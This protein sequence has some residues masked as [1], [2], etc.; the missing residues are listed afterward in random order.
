M[1]KKQIAR[2]YD[3]QPGATIRSTE[4]DD[5][6][7]QLVASVNE[8][9]DCGDYSGGLFY[10][11]ASRVV[12]WTWSPSD[13][14]SFLE[15]AHNTN[16]TVKADQVID[17]TLGQSVSFLLNN[18]HNADGTVKAT[19]VVDPD[20]ALSDLKAFLA[21]A[22][23]NDGTIKSDGISDPAL[24]NHN[25][26]PYSHREIREELLFT[27]NEPYYQELTYDANGNLTRIDVYTDSTK[28]TQIGYAIFTY[29]ANGNLIQV[30]YSFGGITRTQ[31]LNYDASGNLVSIDQT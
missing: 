9:Y 14:K 23:Y 20:W 4:V 17:A 7:N 15:V 27:F 6:L 1:A 3:F 28:G 10:P 2:I 18:S 22:H 13:L 25:H 31:V 21:V 29:D 26:D 19:S 24:Y 8:I 5:E 16:G 30:D 11:L 12:E